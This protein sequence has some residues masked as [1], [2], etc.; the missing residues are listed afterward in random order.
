MT[1]TTACGV[2]H[3]RA[4]THWRD[5]P[6]AAFYLAS[7]S[8]INHA[9]R[10]LN[11]STTSSGSSGNSSRLISGADTTLLV[12]L[13]SLHNQ[14]RLEQTY[15][16]LILKSARRNQGIIP[17]FIETT[18]WYRNHNLK[19]YTNMYCMYCDSVTAQGK[20]DYHCHS[21]STRTQSQI[22]A[23]SMAASQWVVHQIWLSLAVVSSL[24]CNNFVKIREDPS[25]ILTNVTMETWN[26]RSTTYQI[27]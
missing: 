7:R 1:V 8:Y 3:C 10:D 27:W 19:I 17:G 4:L 13:T 5:A 16:S 11:D 20:I 23:T 12:F 14:Y 24:H 21:R 26:H 9:W 22:L 25:R 15:V 2:L 6:R 18:I